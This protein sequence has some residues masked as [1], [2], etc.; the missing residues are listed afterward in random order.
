M[1]DQYNLSPVM[2]VKR[3]RRKL[4][5]LRG[6]VL[7]AIGVSILLG[8]LVT[9]LVMGTKN[10]EDAVAKGSVALEPLPLPPM[11]TGLDG[12]GENL[13]DLLGETVPLG[14]NPTERI[15][16]LGNPESPNEMA[17]EANINTQT[18]P[19]TSTGPKTILIN[20]QPLESSRPKSPLPRA[21]IAGLSRIT[22]FG[23]VPHPSNDGARAVNA[24]ARPFSPI[25]GQKTLSIIVG[26]LG[27]DEAA[28]RTAIDI[29]PP[30]VSLSFAAH[31]SGL[32]NWVNQAR[33][34]GH[35]VLIELPMES[36]GFDPNEAGADHAL[37]TQQSASRNIRNLD[38]LMA[39]TTGYFAVTNYNGDVLMKRTDILAPIFTQIANSGVGFIYDGSSQ[40]PSLP[41]LAAS[42]GLP[43]TQAYSILDS[44]PAQSSVQTELSR[45]IVQAASGQTPIGVG[46]AYA[47]TIETIAA[48]STNLQGQGIQ[49]APASYAFTRKR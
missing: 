12:F 15:D 39:Q 40:A 9:L 46:F 35:E 25:A 26:G 4:P 36:A 21:P 10:P 20:G 24:Y 41:A 11:S 5:S 27:I 22:P 44:D 16:A 28:T 42:L 17:G 38:W 3:Q 23:P 33:A 7:R 37:T 29:L 30:E 8:S 45:L 43:Y 47:G 1:Q 32:Q 34:A 6:H 18:V 31:A 14:E 49:I 48:W 13:P 19:S 2:I